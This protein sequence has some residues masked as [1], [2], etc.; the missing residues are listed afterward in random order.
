MATGQ[1][2]WLAGVAITAMRTGQL[3]SLTTMRLAEP[4]L[5]SVVMLRTSGGPAAQVRFTAAFSSG[6]PVTVYRP[7]S[8]WKIASLP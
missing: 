4:T 6:P 1:R 3:P 7:G 5:R 8:T 2:A